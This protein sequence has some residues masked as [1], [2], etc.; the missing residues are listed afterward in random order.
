MSCRTTKR[1]R[2]GYGL[3]Q[4]ERYDEAAS[5]VLLDLFEP[6]LRET[7]RRAR[8]AVP[9]FVMAE[10][11][12][13]AD[14]TMPRVVAEWQAAQAMR[15]AHDQPFPYISSEFAGVTTPEQ[16]IALSPSE[17]L[18]RWLQALDPRAREREA[19]SHSGCRGPLPVMFDSLRHPGAAAGPD[20]PGR[21][22]HRGL[23]P[24]VW[25]GGSRRMR[26]PCRPPSA[27]L[28]GGTASSPTIT[29]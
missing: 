18:A 3:V 24:A 2:T 6:Y 27:R 21:G 7:V 20:R 14:S 8:D 26:G 9:R 16:L 28:P 4:R 25:R 5:F 12:M 17:A 15:N 19:W 1:E 29:T 11:F 23:L 22:I 13:A 10:E